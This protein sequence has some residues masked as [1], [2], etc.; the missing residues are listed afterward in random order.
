MQD[1]RIRLLLELR[2]DLEEE[3]DR[4]RERAEKIETYLQTLDATIGMS[5]FTTADTTLT[6]TAASTKTTLP[7]SQPP[8]GPRKMDVMNKARDL[9]LATMEVSETEIRVTPAPHANY[10]IKKGAFARFFMERILG[11][12]QQ[13]D[14]HRVENEE[15]EWEDAFDFEV[16]ADE[17]VLTGVVIRNYGGEDRLQEIQKALRWALEKIY[18]ER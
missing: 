12:F 15:I 3:L 18:R 2:K 1:P 7:P 9:L 14:R 6:R 5:S 13:E 11:E 4:I 17:G 8:A 10:D 16:K